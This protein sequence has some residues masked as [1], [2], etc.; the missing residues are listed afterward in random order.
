MYIQSLH[1]GLPRVKQFNY[2]TESCCGSAIK[3][4][5][6][7]GFSFFFNAIDCDLFLSSI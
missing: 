1:Y 6:V 4:A 2:V 7:F 3:D 5:T